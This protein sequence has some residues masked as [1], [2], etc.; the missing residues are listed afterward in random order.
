M[1]PPAIP[2]DP[3][4]TAAGLWPRAVAW[5]IDAMLIGLPVCALMWLLGDGSGDALASQWHGLGTAMGDAM[6]AAALRGDSPLTMLQAWTSE[7]GPLRP[8]INDVVGGMYAAAWPA[9]ALFA[10]L[11]LLV[12]PLQDAG[13]YHA[14]FGKRM[15]GLQVETA[16][17]A[18]PGPARVY[19]R[20]VAGSLS[21]LT[22][23]IG[24]V[25]AVTAPRHQALHDRIARTRVVW[26]PGVDRQVP[27]WGWLLLVIAFALPL[28]VAIK[29]AYTMNAAMQAS[30]G[31]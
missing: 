12:W 5:L 21:W 26:R 23:N 13:Q 6:T 28:L 1:Q 18:Q 4:N 8:A 19:R 16:E 14:T 24:H 30:L 10:L 3:T 11:A 17:G 27:M 29:A 22:L 15:L 25:M 31:L 2:A 20:H 7:E 9:A